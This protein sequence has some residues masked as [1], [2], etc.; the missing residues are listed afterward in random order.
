MTKPLGSLAL[1]PLLATAGTIDYG[2]LDQITLATGSTLSLTIS[3]SRFLAAFN[4]TPD[5][6]SL[7]MPSL[8]APDGYQL[9]AELIGTSTIPFTPA[10]VPA[11][12]TVNGETFAAGA[13]QADI[14]N[15]PASMWGL[16]SLTIM[17]ENDGPDITL[18]FPSAATMECSLTYHGPDV[19]DNAGCTQDSVL[20][21]STAADAPEPSMWIAVAITLVGIFIARKRPK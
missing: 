12:I 17:V 5:E 7:L 6:L 8:A 20:V 13:W 3:D 10:F 9:S 14:A 18:G 16:S 2:P 4:Q 19:L 11:Q 1:L 21:V 15:I